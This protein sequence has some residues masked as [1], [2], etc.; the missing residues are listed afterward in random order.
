MEVRTY[1]VTPQRLE[2]VGIKLRGH[3]FAFD[4]AK[5]TGEGEKSGFRVQW[6]IAS[7][8]VTITL[9]EHP[10][11]GKGLFWSAIEDEL[12]KPVA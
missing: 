6:S 7:D 10:F 11:I 12:G 1:S 3:G 8:R 9:L 5:P 4:P 2:A